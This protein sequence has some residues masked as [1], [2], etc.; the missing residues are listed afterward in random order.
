[1]TA[2]KNTIFTDE[3]EDKGGKNRGFDS[4]EILATSLTSCTAAT[5]R[6]YIDRKQWDVPEICAQVSVENDTKVPLMTFTA[7]ISFGDA[8]L[9]EDRQIR[10]LKIADKCPVH[11]VLSQPKEINTSLEY[12]GKNIGKKSTIVHLPSRRQRR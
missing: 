9:T 4:F 2:G 10:L 6:M 8:K 5:L 11:K 3:P 12:P 7:V 1:M